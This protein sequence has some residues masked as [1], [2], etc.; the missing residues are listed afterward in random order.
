MY[1]IKMWRG[2]KIH[3]LQAFTKA[4]SYFCCTNFYCNYWPTYYS[5]PTY[6]VLVPIL[7]NTQFSFFFVCQVLESES[8]KC[9]SCN[10][11][12]QY[13]C[14]RCKVCFCDDHVRRKGFKYEKGKALPCPK[15]SYET[16]ETKDLS[17]SS[18]FFNIIDNSISNCTI[19]VHKM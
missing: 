8:F 17:M 18:K 11:L 6:Y 5:R 2:W 15:C 14:L 19:F 9:Q 7:R 4:L 10:R 12:G 1:C 13:S 3:M 16:A